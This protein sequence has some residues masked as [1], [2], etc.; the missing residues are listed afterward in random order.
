MEIDDDD[1]FTSLKQSQQPDS[2][3]TSEDFD[4]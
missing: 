4:V 3:Y 2:L 1:I